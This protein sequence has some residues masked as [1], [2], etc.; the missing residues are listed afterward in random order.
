MK[1]VGKTGYTLGFHSEVFYLD[2]CKLLIAVS[3]ELNS[4]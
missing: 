1:A 4:K 3:R 2:I